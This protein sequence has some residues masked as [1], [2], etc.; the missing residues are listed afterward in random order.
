MK[1]FSFS[2]DIYHEIDK[3]KINN[4]IKKMGEVEIKDLMLFL[5]VVLDF[6][7]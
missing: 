2:L 3:N 5:L 6:G 4:I 7:K 1:N